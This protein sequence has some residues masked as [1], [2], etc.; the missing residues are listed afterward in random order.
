MVE[1]ELALQHLVAR[2]GCDYAQ[3]YCVSRPLRADAVVPWA[4]YRL[5]LLSQP[6][7]ATGGLTGERDRILQRRA[8]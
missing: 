7:P 2:W 8:P 3:G 4:S 1:N 6:V 5:G